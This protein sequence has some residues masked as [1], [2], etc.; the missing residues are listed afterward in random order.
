MVSRI[1]TAAN[2]DILVSRMLQTQQRVNKLQTQLGTGLK[3][4]DYTGLGAQSGQLINIENEKA[5]VQRFL[6]NNAIAN[7]TLQ[8]QAAAVDGIDSTLRALRSEML[9]FTGR[10]LSDQSPSDQDDVKDIQAKAFEALSQMQFF[11]NQKVDGK[12]IF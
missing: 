1:G 11:L 10:D 4:V 6:S 9:G 3:S 5:R 7:T 8:A 12:Y 2:N